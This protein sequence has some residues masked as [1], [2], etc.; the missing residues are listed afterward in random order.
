LPTKK[1]DLMKSIIY[2]NMTVNIM[3]Y[4]MTMRRE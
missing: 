3:K 1:I 4:E 2:Q